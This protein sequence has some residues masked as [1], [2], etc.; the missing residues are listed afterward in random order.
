VKHNAASQKRINFL[1]E[2]MELLKEKASQNKEWYNLVSNTPASERNKFARQASFMLAR[3]AS[4]MI[5]DMT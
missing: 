1:F 5:S 2:G 4:Q 3:D